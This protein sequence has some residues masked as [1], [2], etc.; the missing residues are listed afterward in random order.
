MHLTAHLQLSQ[1]LACIFWPGYALHRSIKDMIRSPPSI[2]AGSGGRASQVWYVG[3]VLTRYVPV[4]VIQ[5][6][7]IVHAN[8][9]SHQF[10][11]FTACLLEIAFALL[12]PLSKVN[13]SV[14]LFQ[15]LT[16]L[17]CYWNGEIVR[18][19]RIPHLLSGKTIN[20]LPSPSGI[21]FLNYISDAKGASGASS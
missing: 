15:F 10:A 17:I 14:E 11:E 6:S 13:G 21:F 16:N 1:L 7:Y 20:H 4:L 8:A 9:E 12:Q 3:R 19:C 2:K 18:P 5:R